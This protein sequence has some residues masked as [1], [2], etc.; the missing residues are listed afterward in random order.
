MSR[1]T[2]TFDQ[3]NN[4]TGFAN[5]AT[6]D[7]AEAVRDYFDADEQVSIFGSEAIQD[8]RVLD[9]MADTVIANRWH[10]TV[11][12][13]ADALKTILLLIEQWRN[14]RNG[15]G[16]WQA[17]DLVNEIEKTARLV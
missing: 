5:G 2:Y 8:E 7:D 16:V 3:I 10:F 9:D 6:F 1:P 17:I 15:G 14:D 4:A 12:P 13:P 11:T